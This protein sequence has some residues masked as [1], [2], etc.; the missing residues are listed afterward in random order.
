[1]CRAGQP[2]R[3]GSRRLTDRQA[4]GP[5]QLRGPARARPAPPRWPALDLVGTAL[6]GPVH[7]HRAAARHAR[8]LTGPSTESGQ[9]TCQTRLDRSLVNNSERAEWLV[10]RNP[11]AGL[12]QPG[13]SY[14]VSVSILRYD[15]PLEHHP[16]GHA[17]VSREL[18]QARAG[19]AAG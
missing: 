2:V 11:E 1:H 17:T 16:H 3:L 5:P 19:G 8:R 14:K 18:F 15:P 9:T 13:D 10:R 6:L 12:V 7:R 4:A